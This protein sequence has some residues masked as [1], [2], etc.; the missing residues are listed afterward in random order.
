M[1]KNPA[2][3]AALSG[4]VKNM[5]ASVKVLT[6]KQAPDLVFKAPIHIQKSLSTKDIILETDNLDADYT[7]LLFYQGECPLCEDA[8]IDLANKYKELKE[9]NVRVVAIS[10][11]KTEQG[12]KKKLAYHQW[13]DNYCDFTGM[14]GEN[15]TN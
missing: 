11:D 9:Q 14:S 13:P 12:F 2:A 4:S 5:M 8:L 15:L 10:G 1:D 6:G 7:I 3:Q